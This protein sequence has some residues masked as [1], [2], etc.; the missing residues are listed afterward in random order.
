MDQLAGEGGQCHPLLGP[1]GDEQPIVF[2]LDLHSPISQ[3]L[4]S[5]FNCLN[6]KAILFVYFNCDSYK[7]LGPVGDEQPVVFELDFN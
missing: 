7:V 6:N 5:Y 4:C 1:V 2:E 3:V